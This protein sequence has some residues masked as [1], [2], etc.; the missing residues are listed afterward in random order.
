MWLKR[1]IF[2]D[3][4]SEVSIIVERHYGCRAKNSH[5]TPTLWAAGGR[6][7]TQYVVLPACWPGWRIPTTLFPIIFNQNNEIKAFLFPLVSLKSHPR[8]KSSL[9]SNKVYST[10]R[11]WIFLCYITQQFYNDDNHKWTSPP[12]W[13]LYNAF[14]NSSINF[15]SLNPFDNLSLFICIWWTQMFHRRD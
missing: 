15:S 8:N 4:T 3:Q 11:W 14:K 5:W 2:S 9:S 7:S 13:L 1:H 6:T 12:C 10:Q